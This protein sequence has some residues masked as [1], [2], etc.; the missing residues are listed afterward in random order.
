[1]LIPISKKFDEDSVSAQKPSAS[2]KDWDTKRAQWCWVL[3]THLLT[4][5]HLVALHFWG[6]TVAQSMLLTYTLPNPRMGLRKLLH[7]WLP[8][9]WKHCKSNTQLFCSEWLCQVFFMLKVLQR[10]CPIHFLLFTTQSGS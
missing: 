7:L 9:E 3:Y 4:V 6:P 10:H 1:M 5:S 8:S 2:G